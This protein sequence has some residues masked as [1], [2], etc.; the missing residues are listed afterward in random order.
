MTTRYQ[1]PGRADREGL[2]L[3]DLFEMFP[4]DATAEQWFEAQMWPDGP[5]CP[6]CQSQRHSVTRGKADMPY[7]CRDC[8]GYFSVRKGTLMHS[9]KLGYQKWAIAIYQV[10]TSL[11]GVSAMRLHRDLGVSY[12]TAWYLLHRIRGALESGALPMLGPVEVDETFVGGSEA[13]KH[14]SQRSRARGGVPE[15]APVVG[16]KDRKTGKVKAKAIK[17]TDSATLRGFVR[18]HAQPGSHV[19]S[20]GHSAYTLLEGEYH[21]RAV[22]HSAGTYVI[23]D[24][25]TN[26]I[27][28]FWSLLKRGIVGVYH[29]VSEKHLDRYVCEFVGRH[30]LRDL[31]TAEQMGEIARGLRGRRLRYDDLVA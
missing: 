25:H 19:Y 4:D 30:N 20:D 7:R 11:K 28:S 5:T 6:V 1:A 21:H 8:H 16:V 24:I 10:A 12:P 9:T 22:Q 18:E 13:N 14:E 27:E 3:I 26:G 2:S 23:E 17:R 31:G 15:K 29:Q